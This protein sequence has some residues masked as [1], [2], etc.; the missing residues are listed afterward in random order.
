MGTERPMIL[1]NAQVENDRGLCVLTLFTA[2]DPAHMDAIRN[3]DAMPLQIRLACHHHHLLQL[4]QLL[5]DHPHPGP[6]PAHFGR[7]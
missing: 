4:G 7:Q 5:L 1:M 6:P 2:K 3:A